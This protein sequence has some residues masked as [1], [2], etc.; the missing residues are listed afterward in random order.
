MSSSS[1]DFFLLN[2]WPG[3]TPLK[4]WTPLGAS[5]KTIL[6]ARSTK[7]DQI[8]PSYDEKILG[9]S[10]PNA[11]SFN[12]QIDIALRQAAQSIWCRVDLGVYFNVFWGR[13]SQKKM[14][15]ITWPWRLT[16]K[17]K[18]INI[19]YCDLPYLWLYIKYRQDLSTTWPHGQSCGRHKIASRRR[20]TDILI[21][22]LPRKPQLG[23]GKVW[24]QSPDCVS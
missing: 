8:L 24:S 23:S 4:V 7:L 15:S 2:P 13:G 17:I 18:V 22:S 19:Y 9:V 20:A 6:Q 14:K 11:F 5:S 1:C 3:A 16:L 10:L 21:T 12:A